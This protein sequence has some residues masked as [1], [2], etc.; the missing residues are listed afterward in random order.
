MRKCASWWICVLTARVRA[1][2]A[3]RGNLDLANKAVGQANKAIGGFKKNKEEPPPE[4]YEQKKTAEAEVKRLEELMKEVR[5]K[6]D[7]CITHRKWAPV[8]K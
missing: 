4:L 1:T 2:C 3:A 7:D 8:Q 6:R 5:I